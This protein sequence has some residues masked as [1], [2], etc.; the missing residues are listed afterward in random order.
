[1]IIRLAKLSDYKKI[2]AV[3]YRSYTKAGEG[4]LPLHELTSL[5]L[6][7]FEERWK[8]RFDNPLFL[9]F[10]AVKDEEILGFASIDLNI[11]TNDLPMLRFLYID[12]DYWRQGIGKALIAEVSKQLIEEK[13]DS[14]FAWTLA[15]SSE[16]QSFDSFL[17]GK[18]EAPIEKWLPL[19]SQPHQP[20]SFC[21][22]CIHCTVDKLELLVKKLNKKKHIIPSKKEE[23]VSFF[24][25]SKIEVSPKIEYL[26]PTP[27]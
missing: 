6:E 8:H 11:Q 3:H 19:G 21:T 14:F 25:K 26:T 5:T 22:V 17:G 9:M 24:N 20:G 18:K 15:A 4:I 2:A 16:A 12:I 1:M 10:V 23:S 13:F 27:M 7:S